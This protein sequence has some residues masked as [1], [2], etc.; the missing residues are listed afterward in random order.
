MPLVTSVAEPT[1]MRGS[2]EA[3][4][5]AYLNAERSK[6]GFGMVAQSTALDSSAGKHGLYIRANPIGPNNDPH[7]EVAGRTGFTAVWPIERAKLAGYLTDGGEVLENGTSHNAMRNL[8]LAP[9]RD[10]SQLTLEAI[11]GLFGVPIHA[12]SGPLSAAVDVGM[13]TTVTNVVDTSNIQ[14]MDGNSFFEFGYGKTAR[15]QLPPAGSDIRTYPCN[16]TTDL[17]P[18]FFGEWV[19]GIDIFPG[20]NTNVAPLGAPLMVVGEVGK[21]LELA[22]ATITDVASGASLAIYTLRTK[23][24]DPTASYYRSDSVGYVMADKPY[25]PGHKYVAV[26]NGKSGGVAFSKTI[27]FGVGQFSEDAKGSAIALGLPLQ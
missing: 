10:I 4:A 18:A 7:L 19:G 1:Y 15:G 13:A 22:S 9:A 16:S 11:K 25:I 23:A 12:M 3:L 6:C 21:T 24:N 27:N 14:N 26:I 8:N 17:N 2:Q 5:F 20:R